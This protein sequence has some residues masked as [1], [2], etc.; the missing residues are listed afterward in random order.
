[1]PE[2]PETAF[3]DVTPRRADPSRRPEDGNYGR[4]V[5]PYARPSGPGYGHQAR[6]QDPYAGYDRPAEDGWSEAAY[7]DAAPTATRAGTRQVRSSRR[8]RGLPGWLAVLLLVALSGICGII[9]SANGSSVRGVFN[10]GLVGASLL[11]ILVVKRSQMFPVVIAP[12]LVYLAASIGL[13][14]V[15]TGGLH[16]H[17]KILDVG[18]NWIVYGFPAIAGAS[19]AVLVVAGI[20][21]VTRK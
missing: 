11:A 16:D 14:Y 15:R 8:E 2:E 4:S 12:P 9:D 18:T 6:P 7:R 3:Y 13:L 5:D 1:V 10:W 21:L 17:K 19:A 20:R